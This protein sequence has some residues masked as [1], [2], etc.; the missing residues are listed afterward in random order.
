MTGRVVCVGVVFACWITGCGSGGSLQTPPISSSSSN[1]G[2]VPS[3]GGNVEVASD[4]N[5]G[6]T[7]EL[8]VGQTLRV[9]LESTYWQFQNSSNELVLRT[10]RQPSRSPQPSGCAAGAGCGTVTATYVAVGAGQ[11]VVT[12]TRVSCGEAMR[13]TG[14]NGQFSLRVI[15]Q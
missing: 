11:A 5:N 15:V 3:P 9:V 7:I 10:G 12:A 13:C 8:H 6:G 14:S 4:K 2:S 1:P